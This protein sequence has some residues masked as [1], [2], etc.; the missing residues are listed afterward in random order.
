M[1]AAKLARVLEHLDAQD[2]DPADFE[3][4]V[5]SDAKAPEPLAAEAALEGRRYPGRALNATVP[6]ASGARNVGWRAAFSPLVLFIGDDTLPGPQLISTHL[7]AH[8]RE[9]GDDVAV[10]GRVSWARELRVT[11]F[12]RWVERG[13]QFD[14]LGIDG[15]D[16]GWGRFYT[17]NVSV[18][19]SLLEAVGGFDEQRL[20][21][22]YED[23]DI[24]KRMH[25]EHGMRLLYEPRAEVEHLHEMTLDEWESQIAVN[26]RAEHAFVRKHPDIEPYFFNFFA[27]ASSLPPA[28][29]RLGRL[30]G[31]VPRGT[32]L[33]GRH[34]WASF[35]IACRQTLAP[36][37]LRA[38]EECEAV[39]PLPAPVSPELRQ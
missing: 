30:A 32:P 31:I 15:D 18:K 37:F 12:M 23:L 19:R 4:V 36:H 16:A 21:Y 39:D 7:A 29:G 34:V 17:S 22:R 27:Y 24:A 33:L 11:P 9:A 35:D 6:G 20:P 5:A 13:I 8:V 26:A 2:A 10:L 38:W 28:R 25:D 1:R 14:H 3:V